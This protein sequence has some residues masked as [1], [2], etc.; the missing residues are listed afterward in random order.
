MEILWI[1]SGLALFAYL[2]TVL[3]D[4]CNS[5]QSRT[6]HIKLASEAGPEWGC[7][8]IQGMRPHMEDTYQAQ[9]RLNS[10][11]DTTFYGVFGMMLA[12]THTHEHICTRAHA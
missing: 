6:K 11:P 4:F 5:P 8:S 3:R 9:Y 12:H 7:K 10:N 2:L 1:L